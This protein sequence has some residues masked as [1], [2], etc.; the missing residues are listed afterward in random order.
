MMRTNELYKQIIEISS[1][2]SKAEKKA[3][4]DLR[5]ELPEKRKLNMCLELLE[6]EERSRTRQKKLFEKLKRHFNIDT[7]ELK[8]IITEIQKKMKGN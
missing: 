7:D 3:L 5:H 4:I 6:F 1:A 2:L 8:K